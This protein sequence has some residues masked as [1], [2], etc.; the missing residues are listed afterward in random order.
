[1]GNKFVMV[2]RCCRLD[3]HRPLLSHVMGCLKFVLYEILLFY[4]TDY[5]RAMPVELISAFYL[6][7]EFSDWLIGSGATKQMCEEPILGRT[8]QT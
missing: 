2:K 7:E 6:D 1:M 8:G 4:I 5:A 3:T